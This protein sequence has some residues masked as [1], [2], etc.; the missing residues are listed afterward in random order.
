MN[1]DFIKGFTIGLL[2]GV[3]IACCVIMALLIDYDI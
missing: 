1:E 3:T 2:I